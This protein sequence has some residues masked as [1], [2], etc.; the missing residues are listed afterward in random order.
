MGLSRPVRIA[1]QVL[2]SAAIVA[3]LLWQIDVGRTVDLIG[4]SNGWDLLAAYVI[5][6][7]TTWGMAW[8][9]QALLASKGIHERLGWLTKLYFVGYAAGQVLPTS[10]GGDAVRIA[11]HARKRPDVK[12]EAAGAVLMERVLGSAGTLVLVA[13]GLVLAIG[14]YSD[15]QEL[16]VLEIVF[17]VALTLFIVLLF[18]R[19]T[20]AWLQERGGTRRLARAFRS[21]WQALHG[22]REKPGVLAL[23][24]A[25]TVGIQFIRILAIWLCG[26][27]V[28][29]DLSPLVYVVMGP[30][31]FLVM[32]VPFTINGLGV[33]EAFFIAFLGRFG[34]DADA[35]F[36]T[37]FLFYAVTIATSIPGGFIMLWQSLRPA[38]P[39]PST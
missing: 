27:A 2:V 11:A 16:V 14:R 37:G 28:G 7:A 26:E 32:M 36:A 15:I 20:N 38:A 17:A 21:L 24:L 1:L 29:L 35:A 8:R 5:F 4:S 12:G 39:R 10:I 18:S 9:W 30:L 3:Y 33:R 34:V 31:L 13:V 25:A 23:V 22:Y 19:R 6:L